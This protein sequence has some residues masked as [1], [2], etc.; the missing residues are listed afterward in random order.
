[1]SEEHFYQDRM[2]PFSFLVGEFGEFDVDYAD[3]R[4]IERK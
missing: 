1:M 2:W 3:L 4:I